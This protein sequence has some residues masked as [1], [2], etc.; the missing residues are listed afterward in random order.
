[1]CFITLIGAA[2]VVG[3]LADRVFLVKGDAFLGV[4]WSLLPIP[5]T[6][7]VYLLDLRTYGK[8]TWSQTVAGSQTKI[9][10]FFAEPLRIW[11]ILA[12]IVVLVL[13]GLL[14]A[15][16]GNDP[17]IGVS[18]FELKFRALLDQLLF[19]RPRNKEFA[20]GHPAMLLA[21]WF[22]LRRNRPLALGLLIVG[23]VGQTS[24]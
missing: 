19:A 7:L 15:R 1:M 2:F 6:A 5:L 22:A 12:A 20:I 24:L 13:V 17:G 11:H 4:K 10:T 3:L 16:T 21:L 14:V 9:S 18:A 8:R 23:A